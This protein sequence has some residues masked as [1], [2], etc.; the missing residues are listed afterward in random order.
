M[1]SDYMGNR[2][3]RQQ[4]MDPSSWDVQSSDPDLSALLDDFIDIAPEGNNS[5]MYTN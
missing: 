3:Y 4:G 5:G 1:D 2:E